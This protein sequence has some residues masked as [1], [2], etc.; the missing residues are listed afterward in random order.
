LKYS[1]VKKASWFFTGA[2]GWFVKVVATILAIGVITT[3]ICATVF[4]LY[5]DNYIRPYIDR[6]SLSDLTLNATSFVYATNPD[7]GEYVEL[8]QLYREENRIWVDYEDINPNMFAALVAVEDSRFY[9]HKGVDW[10][11]TLG[12]TINMIVPFRE[13]Y[14]GG[15]TITQQLIKN[16]TGDDDVT[17]QRKIQEILRALEFEKNYTKEDILEYYLNTVYFGHGCYG[18]ET[19]AN[20]YFGIPASELSVAQAASIAGITRSPTYYDPINHPDR[21]KSRQE[22]ILKMMFDQGVIETEAEYLAAVNEKLTYGGN[23]ESGGAKKMQSYYVD[24]VINDV[25]RDLMEEY[26][27]SETAATGLVYSGGYKIYA[28]V[29]LEVQAVLDEV[30]QDPESFPDTESAQVLQSAMVIMDPYTGQVKAMVG[31]VGEKTVNRAWNRA[32][33]TKRSPGSSIKPI[34]VYAPA[35]EYGL[36]TPATVFDDSP[37][38]EEIGW[39]KNQNGVY[40]GRMTVKKAVQNS[41]NTVAVK[42]L[43]RVTPERSYSFA[44]ANMGL[45]LVRQTEINGKIFS[46]VD[47]APLALGGLTNGV[48]VMEMTAAY[49]AF[50][51]QGIYVE[52]VTYSKVVD[53]KGKEVLSNAPEYTVAMKEKTAYYMNNLLKNVVDNGTGRIARIENM[54]VAGK[55]GTTTDDYDRWFVGYTPYYS[56]AVWVGYDNQAEIKLT[57]NV[58]PA[59]NAWSLVMDRLHEG[60]EGKGFFS[61]DAAVSVQY[62]LDSGLLPTEACRNDPRGSRITTGT[63][64]PEDAPTRRCDVHVEVD[65]CDESEQRASAACLHTHKAALLD[66]ERSGLYKLTDDANLYKPAVYADLFG[67]STES[68]FNTYCTWHSGSSPYDPNYIE[69]FPDDPEDDGSGIDNGDEPSDPIDPPPPSEVDEGDGDEEF[70]LE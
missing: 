7:T 55:T 70:P 50:A 4:S 47:Y 65:I 19:A 36:I 12:A 26:G 18:I 54:A 49:C 24:Q 14:G 31:G 58:N 25:I 57:T 52:P 9:S 27:Y 60:L 68:P 37:Y 44:T 20:T 59:A 69:E 23:N 40:T 1:S 63:F 66:V 13:N 38:D 34:S 43:D 45:D 64:L 2:L 61:E 42:V 16:I 11:R 29:D 46:D 51:N 41:T 6:L 10:I 28:N 62:C 33:M 32:T 56:A 53:S 48:S 22:L 35:L 15:S 8:E 39:P 3:A 30:Y 5:I 21:N 17:V 67:V